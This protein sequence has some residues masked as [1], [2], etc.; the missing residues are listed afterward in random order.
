MFEA[1]HDSDSLHIRMSAV[2]DNIDK[3]GMAT[4]RFL[5][6]PGLRCEQFA[7]L[8]G[9]REALANAVLHG[10]KSDASMEISYD[11]RFEDDFLVMTVED[12]GAGFDHGNARIVAPEPEATSGRGLPILHQYFNDVRYSNNGKRLQ[13]TMQCVKGN[14]MSEII[15]DGAAAVYKPHRDIVASISAELREEIKVLIEEG[16]TDLTL[17]MENV[18]MVD[19][20]GMGLLIAVH[21]SLHKKNGQLTVRNA[22]DDIRSLMRTMRLDKHFTVT[23]N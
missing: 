21:N 13:L 7:V 1:V 2:L 16:I 5:T 23:G 20:I 8:L 4:R 11:V 6:Q 3:A 18:S 17:D 12:Q 10:S 19:S 14:N 22:P 15:R 9:M